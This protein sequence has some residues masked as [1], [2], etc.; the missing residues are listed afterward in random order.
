MNNY[1]N[2]KC[3]KIFV[4]LLFIRFIPVTFLYI[5]RPSNLPNIYHYLANKKT[6]V[7]IIMPTLMGFVAFWILAEAWKVSNIFN[8]Y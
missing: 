6:L 8:F 5:A 3:K 7:E 1:N 4:K 2:N